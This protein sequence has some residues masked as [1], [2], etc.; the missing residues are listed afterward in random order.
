[1]HAA[2]LALREASPDAVALPVVEGELEALDAYLARHADTLGLAGGPSLFWVERITDIDLSAQCFR[3]PGEAG[4]VPSPGGVSLSEERERMESQGIRTDRLILI[5]GRSPDPSMR[6]TVD[7][8][9]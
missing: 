9:T 8:E 1:V 4:H 5:F 2:P 7:C 3:L 6:H